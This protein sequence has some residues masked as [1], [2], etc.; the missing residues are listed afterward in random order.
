MSSCHQIFT[1]LWIA[2]MFAEG[3][4]LALLLARRAYRDY[5]AFTT[6]VSFCVA[7]SLLLF[8]VSHDSPSLYQPVKWIAYIP[9]LAILIA[10]VLEVLYRLFHPFDTLPRKT[11][12][13]FV[14]ATAIVAV[15]AITFAVFHPGAQPTA[16][17]TFARAMDQV[18]SWVL[19]SVFVFVALFASYFG[20]PWRHRVYGVGLG[21]LLYLAVDVAVTTAMTQ[22]RL[23][24]WNPVWLLDMVAFLAACLIWMNYFRKAEVPRSV[25]SSE[26]IKQI[27]AI[28]GNFVNVI[29][30]A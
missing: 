14:Q 27:R 10:V 24:P 23:A 7:R 2:V 3:S 4:L 28:L 22:L 5:P 17:M 21:F 18:V 11:M 12:S 26:Q 16:W 8:C 13:H 29:D 9:Q 19:C 20:I 30:D 25:P 15:V 1:C 6:F